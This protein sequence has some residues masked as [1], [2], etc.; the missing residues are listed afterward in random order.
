MQLQSSFEGTQDCAE[1]SCDWEWTGGEEHLPRLTCVQWQ[2]GSKQLRQ[3][4][5]E[6]TTPAGPAG[7]GEDMEGL[8]GL[9]LLYSET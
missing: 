5:A 3:P 2:E 4:W 6:N 8:S 1:T 9:M 7:P